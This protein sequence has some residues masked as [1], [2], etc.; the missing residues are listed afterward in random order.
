MS[1]ADEGGA[2]RRCTDRW[3][4]SR[5]IRRR[6][7]W[8]Y[9]AALF[10]GTHWPRL[11]LPPTIIE[12]P[13]VLVHMSAFGLWTLLLAGSEYLG[14]LRSRRAILWCG[15][16]ALANAALDEALQAVPFVQR[17]AAWDDWLANAAGVVVATAAM[18]A[19]PRRGADRRP[20]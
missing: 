9:A 10:V 1:P 2:D 3:M 19:A 5:R 11:E 16:I 18:L 8:L 13:D 20:P 4:P 7:F 14:S 17:T 12:R 6:V 15:L